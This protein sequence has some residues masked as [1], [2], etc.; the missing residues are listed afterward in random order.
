MKDNLEFVTQKRAAAVVEMQKLLQVG[1]PLCSKR[2]QC[3]K[4]GFGACPCPIFQYDAMALIALADYVLTPAQEEK[5]LGLVQSALQAAKSNGGEIL[6]NAQ[7]CACFLCF[8]QFHSAALDIR[9]MSWS[10]GAGPLVLCP[11]C[12]H[13]TVIHESAGFPFRKDFLMVLASFWKE[14]Q[15]GQGG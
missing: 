3:L 6:W 9:Q 1:F 13:A 11:H 12:N 7:H 5:G 4:N 14:Y 10:P 8:K 2:M 15:E